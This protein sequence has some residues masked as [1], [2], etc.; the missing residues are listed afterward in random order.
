MQQLFPPPPAT[1]LSA[2]AISEYESVAYAVSRVTLGDACS[3]LSTSS[4]LG[5]A[6]HDIAP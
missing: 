2:D 4:N 3:V 6:P 5:S 1:V